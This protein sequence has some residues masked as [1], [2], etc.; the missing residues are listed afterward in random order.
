MSS[1][2]TS[3]RPPP[4]GTLVTGGLLTL[5]GVLWLLATLDVRVPLRPLLAVGLVATGAGLL[6]GAVRGRRYR[7]LVGLGVT[8]T[9]VLALAS[10][11]HSV[12]DVPLA[13]GMGERTVRPTGPVSLQEEHRLL[14]GQLTIDLRQVEVPQ[15]VTEVSAS[16]V[17]GQVVVRL[18]PG[19]AAEIEASV[20][21]GEARALGR[22]E[23]GP[24]VDLTARTANYDQAPRRLRLRLSVGLGQIEVQR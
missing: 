24:G 2:R 14:A 12:L 5:I 16:V 8:L 23:S 4:T 3:R 19:A 7:G 9:V 10:T 13:L 20:G 1:T 6:A 17:L 22:S 11:A 15:G 18:P 21:A